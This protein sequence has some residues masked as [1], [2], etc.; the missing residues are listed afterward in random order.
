MLLLNSK[1][2]DGDI[3]KQI[4]ELLKK[5]GFNN[6]GSSLPPPDS[7]V[8]KIIIAIK[9]NH[10]QTLM[11]SLT[12]KAITVHKVKIRAKIWNNNTIFSTNL[13][14]TSQ[15]REA[16]GAARCHRHIRGK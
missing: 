1:R 5:I 3:L 8:A 11:Q 13:G 14:L 7:R 9:L 6:V 12:P 16:G 2:I 15:Q 4:T 10:T